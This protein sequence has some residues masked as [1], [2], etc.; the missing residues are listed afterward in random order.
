[1]VKHKTYYRPKDVQV[2]LD[3]SIKKEVYEK[4]DIIQTKNIILCILFFQ[5]CLVV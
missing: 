2:F 1:M 5:T 3:N 4:T